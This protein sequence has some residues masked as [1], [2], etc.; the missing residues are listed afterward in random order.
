MTKYSQSMQLDVIVT[1]YAI[2]G[3]DSRDGELICSARDWTSFLFCFEQTDRL[4]TVGRIFIL[5]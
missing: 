3:Y 2:Y 5:K 4:D 1:D